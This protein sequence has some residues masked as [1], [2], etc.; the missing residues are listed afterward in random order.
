MQYKSYAVQ[1]KIT[2][3]KLRLFSYL[4]LSRTAILMDEPGKRT[5]SLRMSNGRRFG[6]SRFGTTIA[7]MLLFSE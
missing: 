7:A 5:L 1:R 4:A 6:R 3:E 2:R